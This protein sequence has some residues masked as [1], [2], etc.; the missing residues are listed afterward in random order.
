MIF[1]FFSR[2][3]REKAIEPLYGAM[4]AAALDPVL[5]ARHGV[6]DTFEGRFEAVTLVAALVL[7]RLKA[8]PPP[9][10]D[11]AQDLVDRT[12][13]GLDS[14]MRA[15]GISDVGVPKRMKK[16]AQGFY[17]R[18]DAYTL[19]LET[20]DAALG[21]ALSRNTLDGNAASDDFVA[22]VRMLERDLDRQSLKE[23]VGG[24]LG[25]GRTG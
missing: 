22:H 14:A 19:A 1:P 17:G 5:Y 16:F 13:D 3:K 12:F 15:V 10:A 21:E 2:R 4:M 25:Q 11:V 20:S 24:E 23:L 6:P 9:A 8:L 7:R 18:L